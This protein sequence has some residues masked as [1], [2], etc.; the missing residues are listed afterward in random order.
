MR[1]LVTRPREDAA[2]LAE[3]LTALGCEA[4]LEPLFHVEFLDTAALDLSGVHALLLTSA[5]GARALARRDVSR[6][7]PVYAIG[8]ATASAAGEAGFQQVHSADGGV[9]QLAELV[10]DRMPRDAGILLHVTGSEVAGDLGGTLE[11]AGYGYRRAVLYRAVP[12][13]G[14]TAATVAALKDGDIDAVVFYSPRSAETCIELMRKAR[15]VRAAR[16]LDALCLSAAVGEAASELTWRDVRVAPRPNQESLLSLIGPAGAPPPADAPPPVTEGDAAPGGAPIAAHRPRETFGSL[17]KVM[18]YAA[19][20][21]IIAAVVAAL[22]PYWIDQARV[23][24]PGLG[25][26]A[27][28]RAQVTA[29][30]ARV[31]ELEK[32]S[33]DDIVPGLEALAAERDRLK[34]QLDDAL[35]RLSQVEGSAAAIR[36][37]VGA[38]NADLTPAEAEGVLRRLSDRIEALEKTAT[39]SVAENSDTVARL[40]QRIAELAAQVPAPDAEGARRRAALLALGQLREA[41]LDGRSFAAELDALR[42][43]TDETFLAPDA[44]GRLAELAPAGVASEAGLKSAFDRA[45]GGIVRAGVIR[46][47]GGWVDRTIARLTAPIRWRR[48]DRLEG[49][50]VQA[51]VARAEVRVKAGNFAG[52]VEELETL[53]GPAREAAADWIEAARDHTQVKAVLAG[54]RTAAISRLSDTGK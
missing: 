54:L 32:A 53:D 17:S 15:V 39:G 16:E 19:G 42:G 7:L 49:S 45:A 51:T 31:A 2:G 25:T 48:T 52:A 29:L 12:V 28:T 13:K 46:E 20:V 37:T 23:F 30:V 41:V 40:S 5:N 1:V 36:R 47:E 11:S 34:V 50:G 14:L 18:G 3:A 27:E 22:S 10:K 24:F 33:R 9:D 8:D 35:A 43:V 6:E 26:D 4:V 38:L 21:I 44:A